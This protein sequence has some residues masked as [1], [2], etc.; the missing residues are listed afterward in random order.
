MNENKDDEKF[1]GS[2]MPLSRILEQV[3]A[4]RCKCLILNYESEEAKKDDLNKN[5]GKIDL[6]ENAD[7]S[8]V[9]STSLE[10]LI[11]DSREGDSKLTLEEI[12]QIP[13]VE[14]PGRPQPIPTRPIFFD[15]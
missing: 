3:R 12:S 2:L 4:S 13:I 15:I 11:T 5:I 6:S 8:K 1:I 9:I 7:N 10:R 14:L